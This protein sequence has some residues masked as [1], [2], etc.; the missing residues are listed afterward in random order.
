M[1]DFGTIWP[2]D[3]MDFWKIESEENKVTIKWSHN[4]FEDYWSL[5]CQF[6]ECG[7]H[8]F[9]DVISNSRDKVKSDMWFLTG[10]FL[11]R[12]SIELGLKALLCRCYHKNKDIQNAFIKCCHDVSMLF[13][14][15]WDIG[16]ERYLEKNEKEW[17]VNYLN[18]LEEVDKKSDAFRFPFEDEFL[19]KY[20]DKF[21]NNRYV[22][23]NLMQAFFLV[24]KC[25]NKGFFVDGD[26]F[27]DTLKPAFF[28]YASHG[29][30]NCYLWQRLSDE[31]FHIKVTGY[32]N[33]I[34]FIYENSQISKS[35]KFY[36]LMFMFRN[37]IE[38]CLKKM[39][40]HKVK[41]GMPIKVFYSNRK[42]H[43]IKKDLWKNVKPVILK[44]ASASDESKIIAD[45]AERMINDISSLDK[46]GDIFRY[47]TSYSLEYRFDNKCVDLK[48]IYLFLKAILNF[49]EAC[50]SMLD[51]VEENQNEIWI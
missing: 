32:D 38:L 2:S 50:D 6:Y 28:I 25:I 14:R 24:K 17:L 4:Y 11:L 22:A 20:R 35:T 1:W 29:F 27:D 30:G 3:D 40:Y 21:L 42:S 45:V 48:N 41:D 23:V 36:P 44:Y 8:T 31:G 47:P 5:A 49:L 18:S 7:Y 39:F 10:I 46:N 13:E 19:S 12:H 51:A 34:D 37:T 43:L 9:V 16:D 15:Y 33:V 26:M